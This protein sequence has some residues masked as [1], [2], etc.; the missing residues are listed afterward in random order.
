MTVNRIT[1]INPLISVWK[2][3][4]G[5]PMKKRK[6][7]S[8]F[9]REGKKSVWKSSG[10]IML[11][12]LPPMRS[13]F[14]WAR[15]LVPEGDGKEEKRLQWAE[16]AERGGGR[17]VV[18]EWTRSRVGLGQGKAEHSCT[19]TELGSTSN[20]GPEDWKE[21]WKG[22]KWL[23]SPTGERRWNKRRRI[24]SGSCIQ[25]SMHLTVC[26]TARQSFSKKAPKQK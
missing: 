19:G 1:R 9:I 21:R 12:S 4:W 24:H 5:S 7:V 2:I 10:L 23:L 14:W 8:V 11:A 26:L 17:E 25:D 18:Q 20:M 13:V 15:G 22:D 3:V 16:N 6:I